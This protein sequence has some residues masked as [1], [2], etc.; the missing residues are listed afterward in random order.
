MAEPP[1]SA[2]PEVD[3]PNRQPLGVVVFDSRF[4]RVHYAL[5]IASAAA[6]ID[7]S[8]ILF[9]TGKAVRALQ[10]EGW[11]RLDGNPDRDE[12]RYAKHNVA[13]FTQLVAACRDL[14]VRF[15]ACEMG[16]RAEGASADSLD[17]GLAVEVAGLVTLLSRSSDGQLIFV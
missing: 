15:I 10:P 13:T 16:L 17:P 5:V 1:I 2:V 11:R 8:V 4:D 3:R 6:A 7:R 14:G 12:A 9:F